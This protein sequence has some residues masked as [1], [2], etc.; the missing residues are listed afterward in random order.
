[1]R[2]FGRFLVLLFFLVFFLLAG[3]LGFFTQWRSERMEVLETNA[4]L[5]LTPLGEVEVADT[6]GDG[7][8]VLVLHGAGGGYDQAL[9]IT[10]SLHEAGCRIIAWS[11]PGYLRTPLVSGVF[12]EQQAD[13][14]AALLETLGIPS[15]PLL[16]LAEATPVALHALLRHPE[17]FP[18]AALLTPLPQRTHLPARGS[19][20]LPVEFVTQAINGD[21]EGWWTDKMLQL[22]PRNTLYHLMRPPS[23]WT[24]FVAWQAAGAIAEDT[25]QMDW[26]REFFG[27]FSPVSP[28]EIGLRNDIVQM[29]GLPD[30]PAA[31]IAAPLLLVR[32]ATDPFGPS[33]AVEKLHA[34]APTSRLLTLPDT[35]WVLPGM[36]PE[37][38]QLAWELAEFF[39][40]PNPPPNPSPNP[41]DTP[42]TEATEDTVQAGDD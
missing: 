32:G 21:I 40:A 39:D 26:A 20:N 13:L 30:I 33:E 34:T 3:V 42:A 38:R 25:P 27:S 8:P 35:G 17:R 7:P 31:D 23:T 36:G 18:R 5:L 12:P 22:R 28:R 9:V 29:R 2:G 11:R 14:A 16:A 6:G 37:T 19:Y 10:R 4:E 24:D 15:A 41:A 1:M